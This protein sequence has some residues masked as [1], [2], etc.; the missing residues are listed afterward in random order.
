MNLDPRRLLT[1]RAVAAAGSVSAGARVLG[2]T[3]PAVTRHV[4]ELERS[5]G[6]PLLLRGPSGVQPTEAGLALIAHADAI[7]AHLDAA[8]A[9]VA[10]LRD[11]RR[12]MVRLA[13]FP[14]GLATLVPAALARLVPGVDVRLTEAEPDAAL[15][16]LRAGGVDVAVTF[17]YHDT[18]AAQ[19]SS[20]YEERVIADE[21]VVLVAPSGRNV[22]SLAD[23]A[24]EA[25]IAGCE[26]CRAHLLTVT[27]A[28]GFEPRIRHET[29]D[30]VVAQALVARGLGVT[31][32]PTMAVAAYRHPDVG[33]CEL[34]GLG[35]RRVLARFRPGGERVPST[36]AVLR[37][38][39]ANGATRR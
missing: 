30:Y 31:I 1:L 23:L 15:A 17:E 8:A 33:V 36:A 38:L 25:W 21:P 7:A 12:G 27:R 3:Q 2:W 28:A 9:E 20:W 26:R 11:L 16:L 4:Q 29:D 32:L 22:A 13:C 39:A 14:S 24:D 19:G 35:T 37:A 10:E 34:S 6:T 18:P 5:A